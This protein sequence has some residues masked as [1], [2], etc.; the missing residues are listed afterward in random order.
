MLTTTEIAGYVGAGLAGAAYIP[1]ISHLIRARCSAGISRL[2]FAVWL[3]ASLLTT[4]RAIAIH[5]DVFIAL[6]GIQIAATALIMLYATR[7]KGAPCPI[8]LPGQPTATT[9][10]GAG[11]SGNEPGPWPAA[12]RPIAES[13]ASAEHGGTMRGFVPVLHPHSDAVTTR[14]GRE[15]DVKAFR[16]WPRQRIA[17]VPRPAWTFSRRHRTSAR[18]R[19]LPFIPSAVHWLSNDVRERGRHDCIS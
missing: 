7:Y 14:P 4:A 17:G 18:E 11:T 13:A 9:T 12:G 15:A 10:T 8:H 16:G 2:A 6:G 3:L 19:T 1:Q 5:A